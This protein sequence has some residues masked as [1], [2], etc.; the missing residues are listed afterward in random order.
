M[1][2]A[3]ATIDGIDALIEGAEYVGSA[4]HTRA[5]AEEAVPM[6]ESLYR[7]GFERSQS[8]ADV[9]W[10]AAKYD[11]G[12][13]LMRDTRALQTDAEPLAEADGVRIVVP[14]PYASFHQEGT[15]R[16][17]ARQIVPD[18]E[19]GPTWERKIAEARLA[20]PMRLP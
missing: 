4:E 14:V 2:R 1:I 12:H 6:V 20:A 17:E 19:L 13:P 15:D 9:R 7:L 11:Y 3:S 18:G 5:Q 16:M 8:P 10:A